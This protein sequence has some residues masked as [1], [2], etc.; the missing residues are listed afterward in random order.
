MPWNWEETKENDWEKWGDK[1]KRRKKGSF[2]PGSNVIGY[3]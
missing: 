1:E 3:D 2:W